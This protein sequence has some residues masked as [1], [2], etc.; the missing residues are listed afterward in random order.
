M[1]RTMTICISLAGI[2]MLSFSAVANPGYLQLFRRVEK[3][4]LKSK[5]SRAFCLTCHVKAGGGKNLNPYGIDFKN[6]GADEKSLNIIRLLDSDSDG[7]TNVVEIS[8][9]TLPG[10]ANSRPVIKENR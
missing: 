6:N 4:P 8:A 7:A 10:D 1:K 9:G 5:L 3:P 2:I